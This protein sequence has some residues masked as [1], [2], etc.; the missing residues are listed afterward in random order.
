M[1]QAAWTSISSN[2]ITRNTS[3][4]S[5]GGGARYAANT[6]V[7]ASNMDVFTTTLNHLPL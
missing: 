2:R 4:A 7:I 5:H 1:I 6:G 3:G